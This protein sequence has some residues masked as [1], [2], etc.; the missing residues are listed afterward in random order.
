VACGNTGVTAHI[1]TRSPA[2]RGRWARP[3]K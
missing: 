1:A 3:M 2:I